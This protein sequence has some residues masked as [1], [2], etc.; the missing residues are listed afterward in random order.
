[1]NKQYIINFLKTNDLSDIAEIQYKKGTIAIK[2]KYYYDEVEIEAA[3][4]Y[5]NEEGNFKEDKEDWYEEYFLPYLSDIAADNVEDIMEECAEQMEI[6]Y[7]F[8][9]CD[10]SQDAYEFNEFAVVFY[11]EDADIEI[12]DILLELDI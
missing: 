12:D 6:E 2:F 7:E 1:M 4:C 5:A 11:G 3:T 9:G 10:I 8:I